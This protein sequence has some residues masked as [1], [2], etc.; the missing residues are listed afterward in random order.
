MKVRLSAFA[1]TAAVL[2]PLV[3][4]AQSSRTF[5]RVLILKVDGLG[6]DLLYQHMS[7]TNPATGKSELPWLQHIFGENGAIFENFYTRGISLSAPSWSMLDTGQHAIIRG[8]AEYDRYTGE[9]YDYLNFFPFYIGYARLHQVDMPGVEVLQDAGIPLIIDRFPYPQVYQS[10]Q[11]YQRG[12]RWT[13]LS[14]VLRDRFSSKALLSTVEDSLAP[15][16][17]EILAH[18][19]E[20]EINA[21]LRTDSVLYL[22]FYSGDIDHEGH[23]T[24]QPAALLSGLRRLDAL[25]GRLWTVVGE[26]PLAKETLFVLI[27]DHGMNNVPG[28]FSQGF[29]L[30]D[31]LNSPQG[32]GHH[33]LTN[34]HQL[35]NF[36]LL[37]L[38]PLVHR[39]ITPSTASFYLTGQS[40]EYPTAWL[41]LDGN[42][43]ASVGLRNN[44]LNRLHILLLQLARPDLPKEI[45]KGSALAV[46]NIVQ[47]HRSRWMEECAELNGD[48][49]ALQ[50]EISQRKLAL[51][52]R[53]KRRWPAKEKALGEDKAVRRMAQELSGWQEQEADYKAYLAHLEALLALKVDPVRPFTQKIS[54]LIPEL[55]LGD[56]N[57]VADLQRYVVGLEAAG[58]AVD[59]T[60]N[61]DEERSFRH[62]NYFSL[63]SSQRPRNNPQLA[64]LP[65]NP[66]DFAAL[67]L[68]DGAVGSALNSYWLY[69]DQD[70]Q[71][72]ILQ[73]LQGQI[74][75]EPVR[76]LMQAADESVKWE[77]QNWQA[78]LPLQLFED[79]QLAIPNG[80]ERV[81][82]LSKWHS[83]R[84]W[85]T[86]VHK[87]RYS[88]GVIGIT[89]QFS[90][91][92]PN[93]P[94]K[95]GQ[96]A[97]LVRYERLRRKLVQ[98]D[99]QVFAS[100]HWNFNV[101]NVNPGGNH[102]SFLRISTH[103]VWMIA[104]AGIPAVR[105]KDPYDSLNF[106]STVLHEIGKA[107]PMP[108]RVVPLP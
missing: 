23:A 50:E 49:A 65:A 106:A 35:E 94:G 95:Q 102:G 13:T 20:Q 12:V 96:S 90:P 59:A 54:E 28:V 78:G 107:P 3:G 7:E 91:I 25:A 24:N 26:S 9:V 108:D 100:D 104:G 4:F 15:S 17:D 71:L 103:S 46:A 83:E 87:T 38:D 76:R 1:L 8:N 89:E 70:H 43:R 33:V 2:L 105:I 80:E 92:G 5:R 10:F 88:N 61:I 74:K 64:A 14:H 63:L 81:L 62:V 60:G 85:F 11:L 19:T 82:W 18:E 48:T 44:D 53:L 56:H 101:R 75:V 32:G 58:L 41:D 34:R 55:S 6:A 47:R 40:E 98:P 21:A 27:S 69:G 84:E 73:N 77:P 36:K 51:K 30:P 68:P 31:L 45:R 29:S 16:F 99:F 37:G 52:G 79:S 57:S 67:R 97:V 66:I 22:D 42:E 72:L 93:V 86:A 39:V